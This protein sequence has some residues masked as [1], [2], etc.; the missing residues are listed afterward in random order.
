MAVKRTDYTE[1]AVAAAYSVI[2]ELSH[3]LA[4]YHD[5]I[6]LV[7]GWVP[8]FLLPNAAR[9][10][11][12]SLDVDLALNHQTL[13]ET[14]YETIRDL[15][16]SHGYAQGKQPFIFY[17][18]VTRKSMAF[19]VEVDFLAGEYDG[20]SKKH[21]TQK[22]QDILPRKARGCDLVFTMATEE[23]ITGNLPE[24]GIDTVSVHVASIVP[25]IVM[26]AM[27][28]AD[29]L[30]EKDAWDLYYCVRYYP[31]GIDSLV[32]V[33][34]P[35]MEFGLVREAMI[36][37]A[38]KFASPNHIGP[39]FVADF[40]EIIDPEER[41]IIQQDAYQRINTFLSMLK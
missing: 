39:K 36:K 30:K 3:L 18:T 26:K 37:L 40:D 32:K 16:L 23:S 14:A 28:L 2:I 8:Q 15:L 11:V 10:H 6:V 34:Q 29:R 33:F 13:Q 41:E 12:G 21:R 31:E 7:G 20:S 5:D 17:K 25:F 19:D 35:A 24:G 27:A 38:E 9:K 4:A 22:V 1:E